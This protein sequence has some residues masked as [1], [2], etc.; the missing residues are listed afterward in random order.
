[1]ARVGI[2]GGLG[3]ESTIDY[4]RRILETWEREESSTSPS[5]VI[6]SLGVQHASRLLSQHPLAL[7]EYLAA[8]VQRLA[9]TGAGLR[10]D[11]R[12]HAP[13]RRRRDCRPISDPARQHRG[14][15]RRRSAST[16][17]ASVGPG[18]NALHH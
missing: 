1:M 11:D 12:Q 18:L 10:R 6:D 13:H 8:S 16:R 15:V 4:Y 9:G 17:I 2:V 14:G 5:I 3:P 7:I